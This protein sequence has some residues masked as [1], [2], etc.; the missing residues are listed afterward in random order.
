MGGMK[1]E[2]KAPTMGSSAGQ[3]V[4]KDVKKE[5]KKFPAQGKDQKRGGSAKSLL[6]WKE[7]SQ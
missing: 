1:E 6:A 5:E 2:S 3:T 7:R 4:E